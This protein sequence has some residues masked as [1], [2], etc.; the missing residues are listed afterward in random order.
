MMPKL[1]VVSFA[2]CLLAAVVTIQPALA[3]LT[4]AAPPDGYEPIPV[5][6]SLGASDYLVIQD[7][8]PW[9]STANVD[10]LVSLGYSYDVINSGGLAGYDLAANQTKAI[11]VASDQDN[12][13][14]QTVAAAL[15]KLETF[16]AGGGVLVAHACDRGYGGGDWT[17]YPWIPGGLGHVTA[18]YLNDLS[19]DQP[20]HPVLADMT[21]PDTQLDNWIYSTHGYLTS[22]PALAS[23]VSIEGGTYDGQPTYVD[24]ELGGGRVLA[25]MQPME[26]LYGQNA[27]ARAGMLE[28]ELEYAW[29]QSEY[30]Q[31]APVPEPASCALLALAVG[32]IGF[33]LKRRKRV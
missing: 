6:P 18:T 7:Y 28:N 26:W 32:G 11:L 5:T 30:G 2:L 27:S 29:Q 1:G 22:V 4:T 24:Y 13:F 33:G 23:V 20:S 8:L 17:P 10:T 14:Y 21:D 3:L 15:S 25:T 31:E 19:A 12:A 16:V 9:G